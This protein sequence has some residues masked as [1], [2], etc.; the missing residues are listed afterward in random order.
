MLPSTLPHGISSPHVEKLAFKRLMGCEE[1]WGAAEAGDR[2][3][4][5]SPDPVLILKFWYGAALGNNSAE[6]GV[7]QALDALLLAKV[8]RP[9][10]LV[11]QML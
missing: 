11:R 2:R 7:E 1:F 9:T 3:G 8:P 5:L 4:S 10:A 6:S